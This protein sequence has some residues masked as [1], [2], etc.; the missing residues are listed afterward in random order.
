MNFWQFQYI[1][2]STGII[3]YFRNSPLMNQDISEFFLTLSCPKANASCKCKKS[4]F[5]SQNCCVTQKKPFL[6][7]LIIYF[8]ATYVFEPCKTPFQMNISKLKLFILYNN[9]KI[10]MS[11]FKNK[12]FAELSFDKLLSWNLKI[13]SVFTRTS[14]I[15]IREIFINVK[16]Q[17]SLKASS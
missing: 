7:N 5:I 1:S 3:K 6:A 16:N 17:F 12:M 15:Q 9:K 10:L 4:P 2:A 14:Y 13:V 11:A 8:K